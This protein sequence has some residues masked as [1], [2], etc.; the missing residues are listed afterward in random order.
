MAGDRLRQSAYEIFSIECRFQ[1]FKFGPSRF[2]KACARGCQR[3]VPLLKVIIYQLL[4]CLTWK[5]LQ[6]GTDMLPN[7]TSTSD[8]LLRIVNIDDLD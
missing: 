6:I 8:E 3:G 5:W 7:I 1:K 4:A 2:K